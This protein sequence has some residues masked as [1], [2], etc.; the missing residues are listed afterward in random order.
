MELLSL[1]ALGNVTR[2]GYCPGFLAPSLP[3]WT[4]LPGQR[5]ASQQELLQG[6]EPGVKAPAAD[7][8]LSWSLSSKWMEPE[9]PRAL[10]VFL[11]SSV[12]ASALAVR[13]PV[14]P[15]SPRGPPES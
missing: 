3:R 4:V 2:S 15:S 11:L 14:L 1:W 7:P 10:G 12:G 9:T 13:L 8:F 5:F 6:P